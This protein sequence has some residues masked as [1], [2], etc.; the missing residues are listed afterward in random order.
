MTFDI[1]TVVAVGGSAYGV[2]ATIKEAER[3]L[4]REDR[5][6]KVRALRFYSC[7]RKELT[8]MCG[9][10]LQI[11]APADAQCARMEVTP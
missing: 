2:G 8:F 9:V 3:N 1:Q 4:R 10:D 11:L 5:S 7:E 6:A